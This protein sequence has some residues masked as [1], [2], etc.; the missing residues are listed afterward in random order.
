MFVIFIISTKYW[1]VVVTQSLIIKSIMVPTT[2]SQIRNDNTDR[3]P[4]AATAS[5]NNNPI[6]TQNIIMVQTAAEAAAFNASVASGFLLWRQY[7]RHFWGPFL[8]GHISFKNW[9][10]CPVLRV[11]ATPF[12]STCL[13]IRLKELPFGL[14]SC[15][16]QH[17]EAEYT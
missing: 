2:R 15:N 3:T 8:R 7:W 12:K 6:T 13:P 9:T 11:S 1:Y 10:Y 5:V 17:E 14:Y 4:A 16:G